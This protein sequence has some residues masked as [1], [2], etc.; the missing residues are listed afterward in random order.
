MVRSYSAVTA[1]CMLVRRDVFDELGGFDET[2]A[3]RASTTPTSAS[4]WARPAT[5]CST[6][7]TPSSIHYESV[8]RGLSGYAVDFGEFLQRW[9]G[10]LHHEDPFYSP[11]L[12]RVFPWCSPRLPGEDEDWFATVGALVPAI[13][14][15]VPATRSDPQGTL[16]QEDR[17]R[18]ARR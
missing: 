15:A 13:A 6:P 2:L 14:A 5:G 12:T 1:A 18:S 16:P 11:N 7:R 9:W 8:S 4:G 17:S 10:L 3:G